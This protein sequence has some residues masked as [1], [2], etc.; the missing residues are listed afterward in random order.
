MIR[1][2]SPVVCFARTATGDDELAGERIRAGDRVTLWFTSA[3]RD[4]R[5]FDDPDRFDVHRSPNPHVAF[6]GGG[7]HFC[8]G[9]HLAR[10]EVRVMFEQLLTRFPD[11][12]I[13]GPVSWLVGAPE[14]TIAVSLDNVPVRLVP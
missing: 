2:V 10:R 9:A 14:S 5:T 4:P 12:E 1:W 11:V 13:T 3:N 7:M 6:G 8:L